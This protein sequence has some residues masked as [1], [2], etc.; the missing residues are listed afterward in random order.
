M[1]VSPSKPMFMVSAF[2]PDKLRMAPSPPTP[3]P[4]T[5]M[6]SSAEISPR[7]ANVAPSRIQVM[8]APFRPPVPKALLLAA[9]NMP[10]L[11]SVPPR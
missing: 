11:M 8:V 10:A 1:V 7:S 6:C 9:I 4:S 3:L 2:A 5:C